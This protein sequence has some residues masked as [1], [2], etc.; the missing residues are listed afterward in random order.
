MERGQGGGDDTAVDAAGSS[1]RDDWASTER[2]H[3]CTPAGA[4]P[5]R[6][7]RRAGGR[8]RRV[9]SA[10]LGR[11]SRCHRR[12]AAGSP[13]LAQELARL[14][15]RSDLPPTLEALVAS[16]I[17]RLPARVAR[18]VRT[19]AVIGLLHSRGCCCHRR[20]HAARDPFRSRSSQMAPWY[21]TATTSGSPTKPP[22]SSRRRGSPLHDVAWCMSTPRADS[23]RPMRHLRRSW[24]TTGSRRATTPERCDGPNWQAKRR[25]VRAPALRR[26]TTSSG[27]CWLRNVCIGP[28]PRSWASPN[29]SQRLR[30]QPGGPLSKRGPSSRP[31]QR[32]R[33]LG[34]RQD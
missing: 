3:Q 10:P 34:P 11:G 33:H 32:R 13:L 17:D 21:S 28:T 7:N 8:D 27:R 1:A 9:R 26:H 12:A 5:A 29:A 20:D 31:L 23:N 15:P 24:P 19:V 22:A 18:L 14:G 30:T 4:G 2:W 16:R 25:S 6:R